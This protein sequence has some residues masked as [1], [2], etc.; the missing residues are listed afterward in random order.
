MII[1]PQ[2]APGSINFQLKVSATY[3][4]YDPLDTLWCS[5]LLLLDQLQTLDARNRTHQLCALRLRNFHLEDA[6]NVGHHRYLYNRR[7]PHYRHS[8]YEYL[9]DCLIPFREFPIYHLKLADRLALVWKMFCIQSYVRV[10]LHH[11]RCR[12]HLSFLKFFLNEQMGLES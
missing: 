12:D 10:K 3:L 8:D 5:D 6:D 11:L 7:G 9:N 2:I 1:Y 4:F